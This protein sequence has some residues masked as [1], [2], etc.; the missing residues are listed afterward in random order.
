MLHS[1]T[2]LNG[3]CY[4]SLLYSMVYVTKYYYAQWCLIHSATIMNS[5]CYIVLLHL[6]VIVTYLYYNE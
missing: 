4:I 2:I 1:A 5:V 3:D 6:M